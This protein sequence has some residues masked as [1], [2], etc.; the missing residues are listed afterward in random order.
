MAKQIPF[1][2]ADISLQLTHD[3]TARPCYITY[4]ID[5]SDLA[6]SPDV[7]A[8][9]QYTA[10]T[11]S[12]SLLSY[13]D[14]NVQITQVTARI[15]VADDEPVIGTWTQKARGLLS[16]GSVPVNNAL[17]V[18]KRTS[19]GGRRGRGRLFM[20]WTLDKDSVNEVGLVETNALSARQTAF[21]KWMTELGTQ[22]SP[23]VLLHGSGASSP[24]P[25]D[26]VTSLQ[27]VNL[28][29]TQRRRLGR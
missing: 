19:R 13:L 26:V 9:A 20:P 21:N 12:G 6:Q 14:T 4:G 22:S 15:G 29:G 10:F 5:T 17:L 27:C 1:G 2:Y 7:V 8:Q 25:P 3:L 16:L 24:G 23:M 28:I 11:A 18:H